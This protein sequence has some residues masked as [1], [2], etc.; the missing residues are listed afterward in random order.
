MKITKS[1]LKQIIREE[2]EAE[3]ISETDFE[4]DS[5]WQKEARALID[6]LQEFSDRYVSL[7]VKSGMNDRQKERHT[8]EGKKLSDKVNQVEDGIRSARNALHFLHYE[9]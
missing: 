4:E 5:H 8:E 3:T 6:L 9:F 2:L 1:K 7:V